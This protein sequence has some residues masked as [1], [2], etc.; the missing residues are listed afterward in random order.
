MS[1]HQRIPFAR[2]SPSGIRLL[3]DARSPLSV[4]DRFGRLSAIG[5]P[6][7]CKL[8]TESRPVVICECECGRILCVRT[9][10][11]LNGDTK[12]CGCLKLE[13]ARSANTTH[14]GTY[15]PLYGIWSSMKTRC[16][17]PGSH[18]FT[19]YGARG[20][21]ICDQWREDFAVFA[22]WAE[23]T[24]YHPGLSIERMNCDAGYFPENCIWIPMAQQGINR[25]P[26]KWITAFGETKTIS[27]WAD[28]PRCPV[29][30]GT[31][32]ARIRTGWP[33]EKAISIPAVPGGNYP[34]LVG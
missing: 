5:R 22:S 3:T 29:K 8:D 15:S 7:Y 25:R 19:W 23:S 12:S 24:G 34:G 31:L 21:G 17:T 9:R 13:I 26:T 32:A 1:A 18:G 4:G 2:R 27:A 33:H 28:D 14:G 16:Y 30:R 6:F 20:I 11:L 10:T